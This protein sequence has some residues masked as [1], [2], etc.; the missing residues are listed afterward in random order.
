MGK[1]E[2]CETKC[3][4]ILNNSHIFQCFVL[5]KENQNS[6]MDKFLDGY[7]SEKIMCLRIWRE[8]M[9]EREKYLGTQ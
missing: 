2:Y 8:N 4:E 7:T 1:I 6:D 5:N 3:G 9:K